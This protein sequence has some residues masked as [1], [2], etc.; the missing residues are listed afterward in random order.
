MGPYD[1]SGS[2]YDFIFN[3]SGSAAG[4]SI[5]KSLDKKI[6]PH[7]LIVHYVLLLLWDILFANI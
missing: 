6:R 7:L 1:T 3:K 5:A 4:P 2:I